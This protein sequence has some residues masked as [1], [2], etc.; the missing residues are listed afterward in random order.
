MVDASLFLKEGWWLLE[1]PE[2]IA[3]RLV[4]QLGSLSWRT[5]RS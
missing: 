3:Q 4:K 1:Q 5:R 2:F